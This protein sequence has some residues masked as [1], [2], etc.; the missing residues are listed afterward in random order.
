MNT[1]A[2]VPAQP[3]LNN[4]DRSHI[5][6]NAL[7]LRRRLKLSQ[8]EFISK[9]LT[10]EEN[11]PLISVSKLS[12]FEK[13]DSHDSENLAR[14]IAEKLSVDPKL[15]QLEPD[16]FAKNLDMLIESQRDAHGNQLT[17]IAQLVKKTS[18]VEILVN[19]ISDYLVDSIIS[20]ELKPGDK[21]PSD[22]NLSTMF[23]VGRSSIRE[24]LKVLSALGLITILPGQGTFIASD[25]TQFFLTPLS[26]TFLIG[27]KN[28][29][30]VISV[31]NVLEVES[32]RLAAQHATIEDLNTL[33]RIF[34]KSANAY[35]ERN[36]QIFLDLDLD[37]HLA[38]AQC[39]HN[40]ILYN[41][42]LTA[43]KLIKHISKSGM[44]NLDH[45]VSIY[46]E[47]SDIYIAIMDRDPAQAVTAMNTHLE[48]AHK[49][50]QLGGN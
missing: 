17:N 26:W 36:L 8:S 25:S 12:N 34:E 40:P 47:H 43:R 45:L 21:L 3:L 6:E 33:S 23:N 32:T 44:V 14:I 5:H 16:D 9:Y 2:F 41:L 31:R 46:Q 11:I 38:V 20:G 50:Y 15:F 30:H 28:A 37:F 49:R 39:S 13:R 19:V 1:D 18:S 10:D 24:A 42:L 22:R 4:L 29:E 7:L 48:N 35:T 27:E